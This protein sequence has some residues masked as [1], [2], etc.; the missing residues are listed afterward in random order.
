MPHAACAAP[1]AAARPR[2][3][4]GAIARAH[5]DELVTHH[6]VNRQQHAVLDALCRCRTAALGGHLD[7]CGDCGYS[8]PSYNSCRNRH[9]PKCQALA[10][11]RWLQQRRERMVDVHHF[12]VVFTLPAQLRSVVMRNRERLFSLLFEAASQTL[13]Q[14]AD[15]EKRLGAQLGLSAVLH[16]W[17]RDLGFHPH[18][19]CVVTGGGLSADG[20][21][22]VS[23]RPGFLFPV[24]V[25]GALFRGKYLSA[26]TKMYQRGQLELGPEHAHFERLLDSLRGKRWV[27]YCKPPFGDAAA[28]YAYLGRYTHRV[29]ISNARL[30]QVDAERVRFRTRHGKHATLR[31]VEFLRRLLLHV[32]PKSFVRIRHYGLL[33]PSNV[34]TK[35]ATAQA[36][37]DSAQSTRASQ[38]SQR[39]APGL[40][41][42]PSEPR[43]AEHVR[44]YYELTQIDLR[45]CPACR[46]GRL[47][48]EPLPQPPRGP[49]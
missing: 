36:L 48:H 15:D 38:P 11:H 34:G 19:H 4:V 37:R 6:P 10:Q 13:L 28:V 42:E 9:C 24:R 43:P 49:P 33:A 5:R 26:L 35:L 25:M 22:W 31:P 16:T 32:L 12:H 23:T 17:S 21:R 1:A 47:H 46:Q 29:G 2:Y 41:T 27:V 39:D 40:D 8:R 44:L 18:L 7:R 14:L 30:L 45:V 20:S 3:E